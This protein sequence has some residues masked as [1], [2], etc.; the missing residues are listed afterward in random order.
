MQIGKVVWIILIMLI[1]SF[2]NA[3]DIKDKEKQKERRY[4]LEEM[5]V[6]VENEQILSG[7]VS[8][9][10]QELKNNYTEINLADM[11]KD[12]TGI[13]MTTGGRGESSTRIR[14]LKKENVKIMIDGSPVGGGYFGNVVLS[15]I[16]KFDIEEI[17]ILK[18]SVSPLYGSNSGGGV[19]NFITRKPTED[20]W[21]TLKT[22]IMRNN[23][24][25]MQITTS[26]KFHYWDYW[27]SFSGFKTDG[28][29]LSEDFEA[30]R[31]QD[32]GVRAFT[33]N[34][35]YDI[36]T[37]LNFSLYDYHSIGLSFGY[38][39]ADERNIPSNI[40][41]RRYRKFFDITR[42][43]INGMAV[44]QASTNLVIKPKVYYDVYDNTYQEYIN[45]TLTNP[46]LD[47]ILETWNFGTIIKTEY[48]LSKKN[49]LFTQYNYEKQMYNRKDNQNYT[50][51]TSNYSLL[52]NASIML[53]TEFNANIN[54]DIAYG[55]TRQN[56]H[57]K[58]YSTQQNTI[59]FVTR[60]YNE[61]AFSIIYKDNKNTLNAGASQNIIYPTLQ[62]LYSS[63]RGNLHL[64]PETITK[65][66]LSYKRIISLNDRF[67]SIESTLFYNKMEQMIDRPGSVFI[68]Q[69]NSII[70]DGY[71]IIMMTNIIKKVETE[72]SYCYLNLDMNRNYIFTE[73][74]KHTL[75]NVFNIQLP[76]NIKFNY[77][78][79]Y[80]SKTYSSND[81]MLI[82]L[83]ERTIQN[84][85][86]IYIKGNY[87]ISGNVTNLFDVNYFEEYGYPA[88]GRNYAI[89]LE[90]SY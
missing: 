75:N 20:K 35:G 18:G 31:F 29:V 32:K 86:L 87:K 33:D 39:H 43:Q 56:R 60:I 42:Y 12:V 49:K 51:W 26:H 28:F 55:L 45:D 69:E 83:K 82:P 3:E 85:G 54:T 38:N 59:N 23:T 89:S 50:N 76:H 58:D 68:N 52:N 22:S 15:E 72:H 66:E 57:F 84:T 48:L 70:N 41:E 46:T 73:V 14:G 53:Q 34:K 64:K 44:V 7:R 62:Q 13:N 90:I 9:I 8:I 88:P 24:Q 63:S 6:I 65:T 2:L 17:H 4:E 25:N 80:S 78:I 81:I 40:Y 30:T 71:E 37:K 36:Q 47:S 5:R 74:P 79:N 16:P 1:Y 27:F 11:L 67:L 77:S 19:I 61:P 21:I 10:N